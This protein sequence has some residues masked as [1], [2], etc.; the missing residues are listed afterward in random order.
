MVEQLVRGE[1][2]EVGK[3]GEQTPGVRHCGH[4]KS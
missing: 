2:V 3:K 4:V 1:R